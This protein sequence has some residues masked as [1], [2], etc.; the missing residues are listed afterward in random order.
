MIGEFPVQ[1]NLK[2]AWVPAFLANMGQVAHVV[3]GDSMMPV[4][5]DYDVAVVAQEGD[6]SNG[7]VFLVKPP[8]EEPKLRVATYSNGEWNLVAY[9]PKIGVEKFTDEHEIIGR[10]VG[11][12]RVRA[13]EQTIVANPEG[14]RRHLF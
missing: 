6:L 4:L 3:K 2:K 7:Y 11:I 14:I 10:L 1:S 9:N 12:Y 13:Y 5:E 8:Q